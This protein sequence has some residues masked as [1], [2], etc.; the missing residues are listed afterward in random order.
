MAKKPLV[1]ITG[2]GTGIGKATAQAYAKAGYPLLLMARR[3]APLE[4]LDLPDSVCLSV[5]VR[6]REAVVEA[7]KT[8]EAAHGPVDC[9]VNNAGIAALSK[10]DEQ[11]PNE[12][13]ELIG[14]NCIGVLNCMHSLM[15]AM[16]ERRHG[17]IINISSIAGRK[18]YPYHDV[19]GGT[20]FFVHAI[21]EG[22]RRSMAPHDVRVIVVSP[23]LTE[24]DI[25]GT[26][27][28]DAAREFWQAGKDHVGP[29][30]PEAVADTVLFAYQMPQNVILQELTIT[31]T[32]QEY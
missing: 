7:I 4:D 18:S 28:N 23:G 11:D 26:M 1:M 32:R 16:K 13:R 5:D 30:S 12:W 10:L 17:T 31:P 14:I 6:D 9:L 19:Y 15:P 2:A 25:V 21:T 22:A 8:G 3:Q 24:S 20:K 27:H 29:I